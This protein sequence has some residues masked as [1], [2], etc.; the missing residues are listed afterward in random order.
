M[1]PLSPRCFAAIPRR[2]LP[3]KARSPCPR[4]RLSHSVIS[5]AVVG[6]LILFNALKMCSQR[7]RFEFG[8]HFIWK[9]DFSRQPPLRGFEEDTLEKVKAVTLVRLRP[10]REP[11]A[12]RHGP[13]QP[14]MR[15]P[16]AVPNSNFSSQSRWFFQVWLLF[17]LP[18][19]ANHSAYFGLARIHAGLWSRQTST[20]EFDA[21]GSEGSAV[22]NGQLGRT[23]MISLFRQSCLNCSCR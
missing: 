8:T 2:L 17:E 13:S 3:W 10:A 20:P 23:R 9:G 22:F 18:R 11:T 6:L 19:R 5:P 12:W 16:F 4:S 7:R 14:L 21:S 15:S 1:S